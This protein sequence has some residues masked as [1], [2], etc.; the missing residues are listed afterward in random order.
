MRGRRIVEV[1]HGVRVV[2]EDGEIRRHGLHGT[3]AIGHRL[4][5][6]VAG[7]VA[8]GGHVEHPLHAWVRRHQLLDGRDVRPVRVHAD[9]DHGNA[10]PLQHQE[11]PVVA[12]HG[13][14]EFHVA[15]APWRHAVRHA[16]EQGPHQHVALQGQAGVVANDDL[17]GLHAKHGR[18]QLA[19]FLDACDAAGIV[20]QGHAARRDQ[21]LVV[22]DGQH[23]V[24]DV[25]VVI[26]GLPTGQIQL[27]TEGA[28]GIVAFACCAHG[29]LTC[30][31]VQKIS[32]PEHDPAGPMKH[33]SF[34]R[35]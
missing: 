33:R 19:R 10:Q 12:R 17:V 13:H 26:T 1:V 11:V 2:G 31:I 28:Q 18:E 22:Q 21:R 35:V 32:S 5:S 20:A 3:Q 16:A 29:N 15:L 8:V 24:R 4:R 23:R 14:D 30:P 6:G 7:W 25:E 27:E 34:Y 9:G